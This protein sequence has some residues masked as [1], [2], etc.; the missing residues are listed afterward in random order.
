MA[1]TPNMHCE[2]REN[3]ISG[4]NQVG[5]RDIGRDTVQNSISFRG[6]GRDLILGLVGLVVVV[7]I[8]AV[9]VTVP[10]KLVHNTSGASTDSGSKDLK[11]STSFPL[12]SSILEAPPEKPA[13]PASSYPLMSALATA[14]SSISRATSPTPQPPA[15]AIQSASPIL[16]SPSPTRK[17]AIT[18]YAALLTPGALCTADSQCSPNICYKE[19]NTVTYCCG[20]TITGCPGWP[21]SDPGHRDCKD[22]FKCDFQAFTCSLG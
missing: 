8:V 4:T 17:E 11:P 14:L 15:P 12:S 1:D 3:L 7:G 18:S 6:S 2:M 9:A 5:N 21:C 16:Q 22:P 20:P 19:P 10:L 13:T